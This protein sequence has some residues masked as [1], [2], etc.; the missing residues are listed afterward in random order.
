MIKKIIILFLCGLLICNFGNFIIEG[1]QNNQNVNN[2]YIPKLS[3]EN[4]KPLPPIT[5]IYMF[6]SVDI[7]FYNITWSI[8]LILPVPALTIGNVYLKSNPID[9]DRLDSVGVVTVTSLNGD[10][11]T[12]VCYDYIDANLIGFVGI[13]NLNFPVDRDGGN[14]WGFSCLASIGTYQ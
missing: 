14:I 4:S 3:Q 5:K 2:S 7:E 13:R 9:M 12:Y 1:K 6:V 10:K 11:E 8:P